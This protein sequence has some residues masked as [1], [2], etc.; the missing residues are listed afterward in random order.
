MRPLTFRCPRTDREIGSG[1]W[2]APDAL[3][4]LF[5]LRLR[6]PACEDLHEWH[7]SKGAPRAHKIAIKNLLENRLVSARAMS[8]EVLRDLGLSDGEIAAYFLHFTDIWA[9]LADDRRDGNEHHLRRLSG[10][11]E[12]VELA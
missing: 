6:C 4:R 1:I 11:I 10:N 12:P 3:I 8:R 7:V 2:A 5:S 9:E